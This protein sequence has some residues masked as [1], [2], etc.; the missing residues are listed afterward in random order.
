MFITTTI[1]PSV[2]MSNIPAKLRS[3]ANTRVDKP[4]IMANVAAM[5]KRSFQ[6]LMRSLIGRVML[7]I[8]FPNQS[9][10]FIHFSTVVLGLTHLE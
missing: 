5:L 4:K 1:T 2:R 10:M 7:I 3:I 6:I 8:F 9:I